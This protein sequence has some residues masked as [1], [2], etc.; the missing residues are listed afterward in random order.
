MTPK[1]A[2]SSFTSSVTNRVFKLQYER[3]HMRVYIVDLMHTPPSAALTA[4]HRLQ[5][6]E[7]GTCPRHMMTPKTGSG[8]SLANG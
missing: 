2:K 5:R 8:E 7:K 4:D 6:D 1:P 3:Y